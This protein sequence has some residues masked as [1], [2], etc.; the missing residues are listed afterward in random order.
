[1][2]PET[3]SPQ[4][5]AD[6]LH[7]TRRTVYAWIHEGKLVASKVGPKEWRITA[8]AIE[9]MTKMD[10]TRPRYSIK[11]VVRANR[12]AARRLV[13]EGIRIGLGMAMRTDPRDIQVEFPP[14]ETQDEMLE[15]M[16]GKRYAESLRQMRVSK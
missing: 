11:P 16:V 8:E 14:D 1:M 13:Q 3:Y 7:V 6:H 15:G 2:V 4:E 5:V 10:A 12:E 9:A